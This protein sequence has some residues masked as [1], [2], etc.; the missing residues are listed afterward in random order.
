MGLPA[1]RSIAAEAIAR[2][3]ALPGADIAEIIWRTCRG[4]CRTRLDGLAQRIEPA[5]GWEDLVL[6]EPQIQSLRQIAIHVRHR[7]TVYDKWGFGAKSS[8]GL[9][10]SALLPVSAAPAKQWQPRFLPPN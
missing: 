9:G 6:P 10:I 7:A 3:A 4:R 8:R 2:A 1:I 5:A